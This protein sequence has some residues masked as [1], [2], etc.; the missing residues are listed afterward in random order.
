MRFRLYSAVHFLA[1]A[2]MTFVD[3]ISVGIIG[4]G[5]GGGGSKSQ[6]TP[7]ATP[8]I[9]GF[10]TAPSTITAGGSTTL[11][12]TVANAASL[13]IDN[14][15]GTVTGTSISV[16]PSQTTTYTLTAT[17]TASI[18]VTSKVIVTVVAAPSITSFTAMPSNLNPVTTGTTTATL[19]WTVA[20]QTEVSIDNGIGTVTGNSTSVTP[21]NTTTYTLTAKNAAG[22]TVTATA[23]VGVRNNLGVLA[24]LMY[25]GGDADGTGASAT[26]QEPG[27]IAADGS[28][29]LYVADTDNN[30]IRKVTPAGVVTTIASGESIDP[31]SAFTHGLRPQ[32]SS[33]TNGLVSRQRLLRSALNKRPKANSSNSLIKNAGLNYPQ[34]IA[35]SSDGKTIYVADTGN[36]II[37]K[38]VIAADGSATMSTLA[39]TVGTVG[40]CG[41]ADGTGVAASFCTPTG[42]AVDTN[43]NLYV[44]DSDNSLIRKI[45]P[46]GVVS[47]LAGSIGTGNTNNCGSADGIGSAASFCYPEGIAVDA[48]GT[49]YVADSSYGTIREITS[50]GVVSTLAGTPGN[51]G[52]SDGTGSAASFEEPFGIAVDASRNLYVADVESNTIRKITSAGV[53][54]T[55]AGTTGTSGSSDGTGSA[56]S[57]EVPFGIAVDAGGNLYVAD[58]GN[59]TIRKITPAGAVST[60]AGIANEGC[61]TANGTNSTASFCEPAGIAVD[62][63]GNVYVADSGNNTI[64]KITPAG[65]VSTLAGTAGTWGFADGAGSSATFNYPEGIAVDANGNVYVADTGNETIRKIVIGSDGSA[66]VSTLAGSAGDCGSSDGTGV[67]ASFCYPA[68]ITVDKSGNLYVADTRNDTI[69]KITPAGIVSTLAGTAGTAGSSDGTGSAASF[70]YPGGITVVGDGTLY[71]ADAG[72][73]MVRKITPAGVVS[74]LAGTG[75]CGHSDGEGNAASFCYPTDVAIDSGA[76]IYVADGS[77]NTIRRITPAGMVTTIIGS[78]GNPTASTGPLPASLYEPMSLAVDSTD[79]LFIAVPNAILTLEP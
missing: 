49:L 7:P 26:F 63:G 27:A 78:Y 44:T 58:S 73:N 46:A 31:A 20:D 71:V 77:S 57:F 68:D 3:S 40:N 25:P 16:K 35:V 66:T 54:S 21:A 6:P 45:T 13:S 69:R 75:Q 74:T 52:S 48:G 24:G 14:G 50:A 72:N 41:W 9:T 11:S 76:N 47:T 19:S 4:C 8:S 59:N 53:V 62:V 37:R 55:L 60:L 28:G 2:V 42:I 65:V 61:G 39:G 22:T 36:D 12:W 67:A 34:G 1:M 18:S 29:N 32:R 5:G 10:T 51:Y 33:A 79:N 70:N 23:T 56:A 30:E 17:N 64:R 15:V 43:G 38:I